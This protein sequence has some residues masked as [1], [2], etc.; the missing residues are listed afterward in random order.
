M[1]IKMVGTGSMISKRNPACYMINDK[2]MIDLPNGIVKILKN[3]DLFDCVEYVF[4]THMHGDH[5]FDL[6]FLF[7]DRAKSDRKL[8]VILSKRWF[9]KLKK[10]VKIAFPREY[11]NIFYNSKIE[12]VDNSKPYLIDDV[13]VQSFAV[14]HGTMKP[15]FGYVVKQDDNVVTFT[16]DTALCS[17]VIEKAKESNYLI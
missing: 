12:F 9:K 16:G 1:K 15:S 3:V 4:I 2:I 11:Y 6:P 8:T 13:K 17:N 7:L 14:S 5:I 10:L